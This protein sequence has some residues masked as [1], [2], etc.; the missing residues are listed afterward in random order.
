MA[1]STHFS[2]LTVKFCISRG[3]RSAVNQSF[4]GMPLTRQTFF[5][6]PYQPAQGVDHV[7]SQEGA[8][9]L[10]KALQQPKTLTQLGLPSKQ[11]KL[12]YQMQR[13]GLVQGYRINQEVYYKTRR[14]PARIKSILSPA[15]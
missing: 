13:L 15:G 4:S 9:T 5:A 7:L 11:R 1:A 3:L 6:N 10:L 2:T 8:L 12:L 14:L